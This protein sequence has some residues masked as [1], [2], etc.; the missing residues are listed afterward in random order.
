[1]GHCGQLS[2]SPPFRRC[3]LS[4]GRP[5]CCQQECYFRT[6]AGSASLPH[7]RCRALLICE[8]HAGDDAVHRD[9]AEPRPATSMRSR[10]RSQPV[11]RR[12]TLHS[13]ATQPDD[14]GRVRHRGATP[15]RSRSLHAGISWSSPKARF[16][17]GRTQQTNSG[18]GRSQ[19]QAKTLLVGAGVADRQAT[20]FTTTRW[21][22]LAKPSVAA[23]HQRIPVPGG[24]WNPFRREAAS[25]WTCLAPARRC[26]RTARGRS[27]L[28]RATARLAD[29]PVRHR[30]TDASDRRVE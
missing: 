13:P 24:M 11:G 14:L 3:A 22:S 4:A 8:E 17:V 6:A 16:D 27:H 1:M 28:L 5:R 18:R 21:S 25:R 15:G 2:R 12:D 30:T 9:C 29:A 20:A 10:S 26:R 23:V 19:A 7:S